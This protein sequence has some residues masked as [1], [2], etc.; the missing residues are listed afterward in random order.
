MAVV[1]GTD[2]FLETLW[3]SGLV[4]GQCLQAYLDD[5]QA[6]E[7]LPKQA[8]H[9]AARLVRDG[10][11]TKFQARQLLVGKHRGFVISGKYKL[12]EGIGKGGMGKVFLCEHIRLRRKVALKV[13]ASKHLDS[14]G[15]LE[16]FEREAQAIASLDHPNIVRA[17]DIDQ[18]GRLHFLVMEYVDGVSLQDLV[19]RR[20]P[21]TVPRAA[22]YVAQA[23]EGLQHAHEAGWV[24]RDIKP[25]NLLL[26]RAGVVKVLDLG[27]ARFFPDKSEP[28]THK[29][30]ENAVLGTVD[31]VAPE[32][33]I[34][35]HKADIRADIYSL[36]ATLYFLLTGSPPFNQGNTAQKLLY[37][38]MQTPPPVASLRP[39]VP[40][41]LAAVVERMMAK[42][43]TARFQVPAEVVEALRP[44]TGTPIPLPTEEEIPPPGVGSNSPNVP[45]SSPKPSP[46]KPRPTPAPSAFQNTVVGE[47]ETAIQTRGLISPGP[48]DA[49]PKPTPAEVP[50]HG[51]VSAAARW[52]RQ[53]QLVMAVTAVLAVGVGLVSFRLTVGG[54]GARV[55]PG[56]SEAIDFGQPQ[57]GA[58]TER[59]GGAGVNEQAERL[60]APNRTL[61]VNP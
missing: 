41:A 6:A 24:H 7:P 5:L 28:L 43:P 15:A 10:L 27:L 57:R 55:R 23:A 18:E 52:L 19:G 25:G 16:R 3:K 40:P 2:K 54:N 36:G 51:P 26:D 29:Y 56:A 37:H 17:H 47:G 34:D 11:L 39:E 22:H 50:H 42:D 20:G 32:Q 60:R 9:L 13:L 14:P 30:R 21:M 35:C 49:P 58:E 45:V 46:R 53:R 4:E 33:A 12:L 1:V 59:Q 31:Y 44:W 38:Q 48:L 8:R 61:G